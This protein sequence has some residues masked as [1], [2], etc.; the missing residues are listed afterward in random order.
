[1]EALRRRLLEGTA[2]RAPDAPGGAAPVEGAGGAAPAPAPA[3]DA[4]PAAPAP[5]AE[6]APAPAAPDPAAAAPPAEVAKPDAAAPAKTLLQE[7][8]EAAKVDDPKPGDPPKPEE[9]AAKPGEEKPPEVVKPTYEPFKLPEGVTIPGE[10]LQQFTELV[11]ANNL[12]Q[13]AA[14]TLLD[15]H[16]TEMQTYA[17]HLQAEQ[18]R[19]FSETR[20]GWRDEVQAD[21]QIGG[22]GHRTAMQGIARMRDMFVPA[23]DKAAFDTFLETTGAGD[24]PQFLKLLHN[25]ARKFDEPPPPNIIPKPVGDAGRPPGSRRGSLYTHPSSKKR[26]GS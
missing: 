20:K 7:A 15:R 26:A 5:A 19:I 18:H 10:S 23:T 12:P 1:M 22:S 21:A 13:D 24:H 8:S 6:A 25:I 3:A 4:A 14:Q 2:V 11:G 17:N 16:L 9:G